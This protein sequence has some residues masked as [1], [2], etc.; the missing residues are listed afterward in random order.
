MMSSIPEPTPMRKISARVTGDSKTIRSRRADGR[1]ATTSGVV[2]QRLRLL[3]PALTLPD[4]LTPRVLEAWK[5][6]VR[7]RLRAVLTIPKPGRAVPPKLIADEPRD[8][9]RLQRW[10]LYP[11]AD[12]ALLVWLLVPDSASPRE[13]APAVLCLPGSDHPNEVLAGEPVTHAQRSISWLEH[14]AM[15]K[16]LVQRGVIALCIENPATGSLFDPLAPDWRRHCMELI[17]M[18]GSY[19]GLSVTHKLA[20]LR[21]LRSH[22]LVDAARIAACGF[23]LGAKPAVHLGVLEPGLRAVVWNSGAYDFRARHV[24]T[25]LAP[26]APWQYVPGFVKWFDYVD[27]M[28]ALAPMP[29]LACEGGREDELRKVRRAYRVAGAPRNFTLAYTPRYARASD[30]ALARRPVPEGIDGKAFGE[31][32]A[33]SDDEHR[34]QV[35]VALPWLLRQLR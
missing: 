23:S 19:E 16:H 35:D 32:H 14:N 34:F 1:M 33:G 27:L 10:E 31:Y 5:R 24:V 17:W 15:A 7:R 12:T 25:N 29:F 8:G 26:I 18:G 22:P 6:R 13:K 20:A 9:Y 30:R 11:E 2:H 3:R 28:A 4:E 21:W